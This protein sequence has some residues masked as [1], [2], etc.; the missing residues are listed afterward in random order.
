MNALALSGVLTSDIILNWLP[1][2][3]PLSQAAGLPHTLTHGVDVAAAPVEPLA[4]DLQAVHLGPLVRRHCVEA[5]ESEAD[6]LYQEGQ[7]HCHHP[8]PGLGVDL[9][10]GPTA[11]GRGDHDEDRAGRHHPV[12]GGEALGQGE[13]A[14]VSLH[15]VRLLADPAGE[16]VRVLLALLH[17]PPPQ[18][19]VVDWADVSLAAAGLDQC[20]AQAGVCVVADPALHLVWPG[21]GGVPRADL[22]LPGPA[23]SRPPTVASLDN[24]LWVQNPELLRPDAV[25]EDAGEP[26][27]HSYF[28]HTEYDDVGVLGGQIH[29]RLPE[30]GQSLAEE[31]ADSDHHHEGLAEK[32]QPGLVE[33]GVVYMM[34]HVV[35]L[36]T[37]HLLPA[38][39]DAA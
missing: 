7:S 17:Q 26:Q 25:P 32:A 18:T 35:W 28:H 8:Y 6:V 39:A 19:V 36:L 10:G 14:A 1:S 27:R 24:L 33:L 34:D 2:L 5:E 13:L 23:I 12:D 38:V 4:H 15:L 9:Y 20:A 21:G 3:T 31:E 16:I 37:G 30:L 11:P 22:L 29:L